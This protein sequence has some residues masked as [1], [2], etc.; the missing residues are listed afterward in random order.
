MRIVGG[1][2]RGRSLAAPKSDAIRPT[3]DRLRE[4]LFNVLQHGYDDAV[5]GARVLDLFAGTGAMGLEALREAP[6]SR[7]SSTTARKPAASS[8]R[9]SKRSAPAAP[10]ASSAATPPAWARPRRTR[11]SRWCSATRPTARTSRRKPCAPAP[12]AAGSSPGA[13]VVVEEAQ[14]AR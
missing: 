12:K 6:P 2:W 3:S 5:E 9:T 10:P 1:R 7:S 11:L 8:A 13:L 4:S 14:S